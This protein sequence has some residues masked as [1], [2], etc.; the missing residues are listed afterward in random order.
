MKYV[1]TLHVFFVQHEKKLHIN[2]WTNKKTTNSFANC[3][4]K[5]NINQKIDKSSLL[6]T[7]QVK[8]LKKKID[9]SFFF[10]L[11]KVKFLDKQKIDKFF[12]PTTEKLLPQ[13]KYSKTKRIN[14]YTGCNSKYNIYI[15]TQIRNYMNAKKKTKPINCFRL[16]WNC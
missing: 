11:Q 10:Q 1:L 16:R 7:V 3:S 2:F 13:K 15:Q 6:T 8:F 4:T 14:C 9:K 5:K 12:L